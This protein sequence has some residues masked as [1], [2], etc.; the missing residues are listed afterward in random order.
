[1]LLSSERSELTGAFRRVEPDV[2]KTFFDILAFFCKHIGFFCC[3]EHCQWIGI[4]FVT[5]E[6]TRS[7]TT[8]VADVKRLIAFRGF[9]VDTLCHR[10]RIIESGCL[11]GRG[12]NFFICR[13]GG[14]TRC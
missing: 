1:M 9:G 5:D 8:V 2:F 4:L 14:R 6:I 12:T 13:L 3:N 7:V 11:V 10:I